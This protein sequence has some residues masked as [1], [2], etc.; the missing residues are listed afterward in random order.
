MIAA[1]ERAPDFELSDQDGNAVALAALR[2]RRVVLAF[3]PADF[4]PVCTDQLSLYEACLTELRAR[5]AELYGISVDSAY[6]HAAFRR[7]LGISIPLLADFH[8]KGQVAR[9]YGVYSDDYGVAARALV[10]VGREGTVEWAHR[11]PSPLEVPQADLILAALDR[12][13][14]GREPRGR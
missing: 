8:P 13:E 12:V 6:C 7:H 10:L 3:Y 5:G 9:R 14:A 4:S 11:S 2:G 1:G